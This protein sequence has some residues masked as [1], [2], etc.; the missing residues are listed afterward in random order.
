MCSYEICKVFKNCKIGRIKNSFNVI[1][2]EIVLKIE[3]LFQRMFN[4]QNKKKISK[5]I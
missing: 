5:Y 4:F 1:F 2:P 3:R